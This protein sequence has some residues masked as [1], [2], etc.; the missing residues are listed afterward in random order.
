MARKK[1]RQPEYTGGPKGGRPDPTAPQDDY[2][3]LTVKQRKQRLIKLA[4]KRAKAANKV[5]KSK[6][7]VK[8]LT[9][10]LKNT[11]GEKKRENLQD[12]KKRAKHRMEKRQDRRENITK[13]IKGVRNY[14]T[15]TPGTPGV[16]TPTIDPF[17]ND[18]DIKDN[19][20][21]GTQLFNTVATLDK[22][23][24]DMA[25]DNMLKKVQ[26]NDQQRADSQSADESAAARGL[27]HSSIRDGDL[28]DIDAT[29]ALRKAEL[30][31]QLNTLSIENNRQ[32]DVALGAWR[33]FQDT[34]GQKMV[35]NA[36]NAQADAP[37]WQTAPTKAQNVHHRLEL[38]KPPKPNKG[39]GN[40]NPN[41]N[42]GPGGGRL[43]DRNPH[44]QGNQPTG[45]RPNV[46]MKPKQ[47]GG[48]P[49]V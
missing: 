16:R 13:K 15:Q 14:T 31:T 35:E 47:S 21:A 34:L 2:S 6:Q 23:L 10:E 20:E 39:G 12:A 22:A 25:N 43:G 45:P 9:R 46:T 49:V 30:D 18:Q 4:E 8:K 27:F 44:V 11:S 42:N 1:T 19:A 5:G 29:A 3:N 36:A 38:P 7:R 17:M 33:E 40:N 24:A 37:Y 28:F 32:K 48:R 41:G 26:I